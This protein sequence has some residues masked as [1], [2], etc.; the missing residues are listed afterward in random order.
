MSMLKFLLLSIVF[1]GFNSNVFA[2]YITVY[3]NTPYDAQVRVKSTGLLHSNTELIGKNSSRN[4][5]PKGADCIKGMEVSMLLPTGTC[6]LGFIPFSAFNKCANTNA[7]IGVT[8]KIE[9]T[10][11]QVGGFSGTVY[12]ISELKFYAQFLYDKP[13]TTKENADLKL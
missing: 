5:G 1:L 8:P 4:I 13:V 12:K 11:G 6:K 9:A 10:T 2:W 7:V 3:N